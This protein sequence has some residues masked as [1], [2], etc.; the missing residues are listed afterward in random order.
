MIGSYLV[1]RGPKDAQ[2]TAVS[3]KWYLVSD[4]KV[5][6]WVP[7][8]HCAHRFDRGVAH[9]LAHGSPQFYT[10]LKCRV[11]RVKK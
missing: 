3:S 10:S 1:V 2:E 7:C 8:Q 11:V 9:A 6:T 4:G 5:H